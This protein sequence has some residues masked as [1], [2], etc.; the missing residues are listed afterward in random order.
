MSAVAD[1]G[2]IRRLQDKT[3]QRAVDLPQAVRGSKS[4]PSPFRTAGLLHK[5]RP[6][7]R[8]GI[9]FAHIR[10]DILDIFA[11]DRVQ[12][13][14][15]DLVRLQAV[16]FLIEEIGDPLQHD[17]GLAAAGDTV[18]QKDRNVPVTDDRV[19]FFLDGGCDRLHPVRP[20]PGQRIDQ[21]RI[22]NGNAGIKISLQPVPL[23]GELS[24]QGQIHFYFS[25]VHGIGS[26]AVGLTVIGLRDRRT[27]VD[28]DMV[29]MFICQAGTADIKGFFLFIRGVAETYP[30]KIRRL[31]EL[32]DSGQLLRPGVGRDII[33]VDHMVHDLKFRVGLHGIDIAVKIQRQVFPDVLFLFQG[34][35]LQGPQLFLQLCFQYRKFFISPGQVLLLLQEDGVIVFHLASVSV[36]VPAGLSCRPCFTHGL[37]ASLPVPEQAAAGVL[38]TGPRGRTLPVPVRSCH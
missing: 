12:G 36:A 10:Q 20:A 37:P 33:A 24:A 25:A 21:Q 19:L 23:Q 31:Q 27:P 13:Q 7:Q 38:R 32:P 5:F 8:A 29:M 14:Q 30:G 28:D 9:G 34:R 16:S 22:F 17:R 26:P 3:G 18:D 4:L 11:E 35:V 15:T 1:S 2:D 6:G